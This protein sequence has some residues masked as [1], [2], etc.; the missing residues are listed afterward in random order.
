LHGIACGLVRLKWLR[1]AER[2]TLAM[3]RHGRALKYGYNPSQP[4]VPKGED[5]AG[6]WT[7]SGAQVAGDG[8]ATGVPNRNLVNRHIRERHVGKS[9]EELK[10]RIQA[11]QYRGLF[12]SGGLNRNGSFD[13][14]ETANDLIAKTI[15]KNGAEVAKVTSGEKD[16]AF[17]TWEHGRETGRE[18][19]LLP[20]DPEVLTRTT[21]NVGVVIVHD[22]S[23]DAGYRIVTAYPRNY[24]ARVG[25]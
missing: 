9:D 20:N 4:R 21:S 18:A 17:I 10:A 3:I 8:G 12:V 7:L 6:E 24:N 19:Y 5:G 13:S 1:D 14:V 16:K 15:E 2:L 23:T 22:R 11:S 25:R